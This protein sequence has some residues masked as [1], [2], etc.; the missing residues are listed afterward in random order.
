[1]KDKGNEKPIKLIIIILILVNISL[2]A[3][4]QFF[5]LGELDLKTKIGPADASLKARFYEHKVNYTINVSGEIGLG[6]LGGL[7]GGLGGGI[8]QEISDEKVFLTGLGDFQE[9]IGIILDSYNDK[10]HTIKTSIQDPNTG[11]FTETKVMVKTHL[12]LIPWWPE[13]VNQKCSVKVILTDPGNCERVVIEKIKIILWR[14]F[15]YT[16]QTYSISSKPLAEISPDQSLSLANESKEFNFEASVSQDYGRVGIIGVV[17]L[18]IIDKNGNDVPKN[19]I[20]N[21]GESDPM[22]AARTNNIYTMG[23]GQALSIGLMVAVFP[24]TFLCIFL[25]VLSIPLTIKNHRKNFGVLFCAMIIALLSLLFYVNGINTLVDL[26][27]SVLEVSVRDGLSWSSTIFIPGSIVAM[28]FITFIFAF[29]IRPP[30]VKRKK[31]KGED[32]E[33]KGKPDKPDKPD[34]PGKLKRS[35]KE[36]PTFKKSNKTST[37]EDEEYVEAAIVH[38]DDEDTTSDVDEH[39]INEVEFKSL[40]TPGMGKENNKT[41]GKRTRLKTKR[42]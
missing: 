9:N 29:I 2:L 34:K 1:L 26:L 17:E 5:V 23:Q 15:D 33:I 11:D 18:R 32:I 12:E 8:N 21:L 30:K 7:G 42:E 39:Y 10:Q 13:G 31:N 25:L 4:S 3:I 16:N 37:T 20:I 35:K 36:L 24:M 41:K 28:L 40:S 27:D 6:G 38:E 19:T 14:N 22:H